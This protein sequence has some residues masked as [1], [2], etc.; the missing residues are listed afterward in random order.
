LIGKPGFGR[1][2]KYL[3]LS[4]YKLPFMRILLV[5]VLFFIFRCPSFAQ[6]ETWPVET[7][8]SSSDKD[9]AS[10]IEAP[11]NVHENT[12]IYIAG[13][14]LLLSATLLLVI[15]GKQQLKSY[16]DK[17]VAQRVSDLMREYEP[18]LGKPPGQ[19][20]EL[21]AADWL[22]KGNQE[23]SN[24]NYDKAITNYNKAIELD[25]GLSIAYDKRASASDY[26]GQYEEAI[27]DCSKAIELDPQSAT[28]YVNRGAA[29]NALGKYE[30]ALEDYNKAIEL[31]P[32]LHGTYNNRGFTKIN[33]H[34]YE[35][36]VTDLQKAIK[37]NRLFPNPYR[38]LAYALLQL[39][40]FKKALKQVNLAIKLKPDY[41]EALRLKNEILTQMEQPR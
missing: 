24:G 3:A 31:D 16:V 32:N 27:A 21:S 40:Q 36:A 30:E 11:D 33:L 9:E 4:L 13:F 7:I 12:G 1:L 25:P 2:L 18:A 28:A 38:H 39:G 17:L 34:R 26:M 19:E 23:F 37:L 15:W 29:K 6:D 5:L 8:T 10:Y 20:G 14:C 22:L 35:E 41:K